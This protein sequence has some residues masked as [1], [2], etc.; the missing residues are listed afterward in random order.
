MNNIDNISGSDN[1]NNNVIIGKM[2]TTMT[3][4]I[5]SDPIDELFLGDGV[6]DAA[7]VEH[8]IGR[9]KSETFSVSSRRFKSRSVRPEYSDCFLYD[10]G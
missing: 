2:T 8:G 10:V 6:V 1:T 4:N 7:V 5:L 9:E 3:C